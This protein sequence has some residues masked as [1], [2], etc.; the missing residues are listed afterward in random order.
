MKFQWQGGRV[1]VETDL[2]YKRQRMYSPQLGRFTS[3]WREALPD[4]NMY[5]FQYN[6]PTKYTDPLGD[7]SPVAVGVVIVVA[8]GGGL[9]YY[10]LPLPPAGV[11]PAVVPPVE[12]ITNTPPPID[13]L[14]KWVEPGTLIDSF[15]EWMKCRDFYSKA[16]GVTDENTLDKLCPKKPG[17]NWYSGTGSLDLDVKLKKCPPPPATP[18]PVLTCLNEPGWNQDNPLRNWSGR[19]RQH[20]AS[21]NVPERGFVDCCCRNTRVKVTNVLNNLRDLACAGECDRP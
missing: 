12:P 5:E 11:G 10:Y 16:Y 15:S 17:S 19:W 7:P 20:Y 8:I 13:K 3:R 4:P 2:N 14:P 6:R 18:P 1:D 9:Y 21:P